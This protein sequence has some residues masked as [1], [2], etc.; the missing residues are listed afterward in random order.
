MVRELMYAKASR[1]KSNSGFLGGMRQNIGIK[2]Y[3]RNSSLFG[4]AVCDY[5]FSVP[6]KKS[7]ALFISVSPTP[8]RV[9]GI[10]NQ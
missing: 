4:T 9:P 7:G 1:G 8:R 3:E 2:S 6:S 10:G 5:F